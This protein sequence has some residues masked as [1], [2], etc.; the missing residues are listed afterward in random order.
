MSK[1]FPSTTNVTQKLS[2][3]AQVKMPSN[4]RMRF[5]ADKYEDKS[6]S[7]SAFDLN[8]VNIPVPR[9]ASTCQFVSLRIREFDVAIFIRLRQFDIYVSPDRLLPRFSSVHRRSSSGTAEKLRRERGS[10]DE[11]ASSTKRQITT[12]DRPTSIHERASSAGAIRR[13]PAELITLLISVRFFSYRLH[14]LP[15]I[16]VSSGVRLR[17]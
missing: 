15:G 6:S 10:Q 2:R 16:S 3:L 7:N 17:P 13:R 14:E 12:C 9:R 1:R 4:A 5:F 8:L 11:T